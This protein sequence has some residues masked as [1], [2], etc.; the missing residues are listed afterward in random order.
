M[1]TRFVRLLA[2]VALASAIWVGPAPFSVDKAEAAQA[3]YCM[4][5]GEKQRFLASTRH[6]E[7]QIKLPKG[8]VC[9]KDQIKAVYG[10]ACARRGCTLAPLN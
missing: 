6:C 1:T 8:K 9:S 4:C 2:G 3:W 7:V 10:P 5:K